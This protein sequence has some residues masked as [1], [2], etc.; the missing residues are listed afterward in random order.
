MD[1]LFVKFVQQTVVTRANLFIL[2]NAFI[3]RKTPAIFGRGW[4][5]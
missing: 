5:V 4:Q 2:G 1:L 3:Q